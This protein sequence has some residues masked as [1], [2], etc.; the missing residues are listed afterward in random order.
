VR[1]A[2]A[3]LRAQDNTRRS[4]GLL[5]PAQTALR[6]AQRPPSAKKFTRACAA[7]RYASARRK[8]QNA[9]HNCGALGV[10]RIRRRQ[11]AGSLVQSPPA[12]DE[13]IGVVPYTLLA[14][15]ASLYLEYF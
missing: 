15:K 5:P 14:Q 7:A 6:R 13:T 4:A 3:S 1:R 8:K 11:S 12:A 2:S 10:G 9:P